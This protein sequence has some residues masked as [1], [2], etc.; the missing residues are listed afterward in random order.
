MRLVQRAGITVQ[1]TGQA[2][3]YADET[4]VGKGDIAVQSRQC[5]ENNRVI[6]A[7]AGGE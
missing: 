4:M 5:F 1:F 6:L 2:A 3:W 7:E